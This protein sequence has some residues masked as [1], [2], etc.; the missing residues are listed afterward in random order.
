MTIS[1]AV[2]LAKSYG[3]GFDNGHHGVL[4]N[5]AKDIKNIPGIVCEIGLREG[6]GT[7]NMMLA[8]VE[9]NDTDRLFLAIDPYGN[10]E[11]RAKENETVR[12][13]YTNEMK[14]RTLK[15]FNNFCLDKNLRFIHICLEDSEFFKRFSDGVPVYSEVKSLEQYYALV[16]LDGPHA[17][18]E[19]L[20]EVEFFRNRINVGG[21]IVLDDVSDYYDLSI[22]EKSILENGLYVAVENDGQK[23]SYKKVK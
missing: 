23:S 3:F 7:V 13:D 1:E 10:I 21:Y 14:Y 9:N 15:A 19:L 22:V 2:E 12:L 8:C 18:K 20:E 5:A 6:G 17:V 4:Y 11:Y 16:H